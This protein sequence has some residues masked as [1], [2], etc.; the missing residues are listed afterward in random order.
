MASP[1]RV[2]DA[3]AVAELESMAKELVL[4]LVRETGPVSPSELC[5]EVRK[6]LRAPFSIAQLAMW[7]L[8]AHGEI[9][10]TKDYQLRIPA[11]S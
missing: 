2:S 1:L 6:T 8:V 7:D 11:R 5:E 3:P 9:E 10:F 4:R